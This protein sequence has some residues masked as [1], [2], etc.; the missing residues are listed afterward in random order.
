MEIMNDIFKIHTIFKLVDSPWAGHGYLRGTWALRFY[1]GFDWRSRAWVN[2]KAGTNRFLGN[3][4]FSD[5]NRELGNFELLYTHSLLGWQSRQPCLS[6]RECW[7]IFILQNSPIWPIFWLWKWSTQ[8]LKNENVHHQPTT[9]Q[10]QPSG[11]SWTFID[12]N[13]VGY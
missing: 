9:T 5:P 3:R 7:P 6:G 12:Q 8:I 1:E 11:A 10:L 13:K 2:F 4:N